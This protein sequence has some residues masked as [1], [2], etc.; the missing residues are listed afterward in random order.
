MITKSKDELVGKLTTA[1]FVFSQFSLV[2]EGDYAPN[3]ADWN[4]KDIPHLNI[5]HKQVNGYPTSIEDYVITGIN[6]QKVFGFVLPLIVVNY[7]SGKDR[8][9]YYTSFLNLLLIVETKW[10]SIG[11]IRT[12]VTTTYAIGSKWYLR[13]LHSVLQKIVTRNYRIL[14]SEDIPMRSRRGQLRKWGYSFRT[15]DK[16]HDFLVTLHIL[17]ENMVYKSEL[18]PPP[19]ISLSLDQIAAAQR[20]DVLTTQSDHWGLRLSAEGDLLHVFPRLC[21]HEGAC[22]DHQ[23]IENVSVKCP[24]HGRVLRPIA[25]IPL[26]WPANAAPLELRYHRLTPQKEGLL[27][28]FKDTPLA[29]KADPTEQIADIQL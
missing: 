29:A 22:L 4:Y 25:S 11:E 28:E 17:D 14:M 19:P 2:N 8:Q 16:P 10:E 26:P 5:L 9:T 3:D 6:L 21:P 12:R 1:G 15:D 24:W 20:E 18:R 7:H 27:I 13:F 23:T